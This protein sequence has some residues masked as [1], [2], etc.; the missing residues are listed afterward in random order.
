[1]ITEQICLDRTREPGL[2]RQLFIQ[3]RRIIETGNVA[4]GLPLPPSRQ[5]AK[6]LRVSRNTVMAAYEQLTLEGYLETGGRRG[7][8]VSKATTGFRQWHDEEQ[9]V[10]DG[11]KQ[12]RLS[13]HG[14]RLILN[15]RPMKRLS[16]SFQTGLPEV[17]SFPHDLWAR[18]L[19]R[20][21]RQLA[22]RRVLA[23]YDNYDGILE[24]K[25]AI[26]DHVAA[27]RGVVATPEQ[28]I[29]LSSAQASMDLV[30]RMLLDEGAL[31]LHEEP[32]YAGMHAS[33]LAAG[34]D[35]RPIPVQQPQAYQDLKSTFS[36]EDAPRLIYATPSH[37]FPTGRVMPL[38]DRLALLDFAASRNAFVLEDD[39]DSE[40]H[41]SGAPISCLQGL[42]RNGLVIY[43][44]TFAKSFMPSLRLAYLIAPP[45]LAEPL[46]FGLRNTGAVPSH[47]VQLALS[48]FIEEGH[49]RAHLREMTRTYRERRDALV[50]ALVRQCGDFLDPARPAGGIQ[51]PAYLT[52]ACLAAGWTDDKLAERLVEEGIEC[53]ALSSLYWSGTEEA[54][55]GLFLG[56]AASD[57]EEI[58]TG[59]GCIARVLN[60]EAS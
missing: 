54:R 23:G 49:F 43:M 35:M 48:Y 8:R 15:E 5:L 46:T 42:D 55:Q 26:L 6:D 31:A 18:L 58:D 14:H 52:P 37:Q 19:R 1:M 53:A 33:L 11:A 41:F 36:N 21:A 7:T 50:E 13:A 39:Y 3:L 28:V 25:T 4:S 57:I 60:G 56:F 40:F 2:S 34:A 12:V 20:A 9:P 24:L 44:G 30:V 22:S 45:L 32:G 51:L 29:I 38:E 59:V 17:R 47:T 27:S 10:D 16:T